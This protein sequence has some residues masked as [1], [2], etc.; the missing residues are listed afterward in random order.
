M[1]RSIAA[2]ESQDSNALRQQQI[3]ER[4][5]AAAVNI[6][7]SAQKKPLQQKDGGGSGRHGKE[8]SKERE[9]ERSRRRDDHAASAAAQTERRRRGPP[10]GVFDSE[11]NDVTNNN[12]LDP[13]HEAVSSGLSLDHEFPPLPGSLACSIKATSNGDPAVVGELSFMQALANTGMELNQKSN[14]TVSDGTLFDEAFA[15]D[16]RSALVESIPETL[17]DSSELSFSQYSNS[18]RMDEAFIRQPPALIP[19]PHQVTYNDDEEDLDDMVVFRPT[20]S[21]VLNNSNPV[22]LSYRTSTPDLPPSLSQPPPLLS[23]VGGHSKAVAEDIFASLGIHRSGGVFSNSGNNNSNNDWQ[24]WGMA[25]QANN[26]DNSAAFDADTDRL[27]THPHSASTST[28]K[29]SEMFPAES[30]RGFWDTNGGSSTNAMMPAPSFRPSEFDLL[31]PSD[32]QLHGNNSNGFD[33][34]DMPAVTSH[35]SISDYSSSN[36]NNISNAYVFDPSG[37]AVDS[38]SNTSYIAYP[39]PGL[40][41]S[42]SRPPGFSSPSSSSRL[43]PLPPLTAVS[44]S[45]L[46]DSFD[47]YNNSSNN[48]YL[49]TGKNT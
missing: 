20:I 2:K 14:E 32:F 38:S 49:S 1:S 27:I 11:N 21:R 18:V 8:R 17:H 43:P 12:Q 34:S 44:N 29:L 30:F 3:K 36:T 5:E 4:A 41:S 35:Y 23:P 26:V 16:Y 22:L 25:S 37:I 40:S 9:R 6:S 13:H 19:I 47:L 33:Y 15:V 46:V 10:A 24:P 42:V 7:T 31:Y 45:T 28:N 48:S 39:P